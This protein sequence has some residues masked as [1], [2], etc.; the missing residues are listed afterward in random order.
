MRKGKMAAQAS[1]SS[2]AF[3]T[4]GFRVIKCLDIS[5]GKEKHMLQVEVSPTSIDWLNNS[6]TKICVGVDSEERLLE[7]DKLAREAG[8]VSHIVTDNGTTEFHG[9]PTRTCLALGPDEGEKIDKIT[10]DLKLL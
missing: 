7:I 10:G 6:F 2:M 1:H 9:V 4:R 3:L 5:T 8:I